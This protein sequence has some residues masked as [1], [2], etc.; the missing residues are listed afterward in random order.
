[1][2]EQRTEGTGFKPRMNTDEKVKHEFHEFVPPDSCRFVQFVS[3]A[4]SFKGEMPI[5]WPDSEVT[6][7]V[8]CR[9]LEVKLQGPTTEAELDKVRNFAKSML[10]RKSKDA[11]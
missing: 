6:M 8:K 9:H 3:N 2:S 10:M 11:E 5:P 7:R 4:R 1:M